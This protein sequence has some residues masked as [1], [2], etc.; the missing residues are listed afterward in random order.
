MKATFGSSTIAY[1]GDYFE[2]KGSTSTMVKYYYAGGQRVAM[3]VG[4][5]TVYYLLTDHLGSTAITANSSGSRVAELR[6]KAWGETRYTY[7]TTPTAYK[8]TERRLDGSTDCT[9]IGPVPAS[10]LPGPLHQLRFP[11]ATGRQSPT[12]IPGD[13]KSRLPLRSRPPPT[14]GSLRRQAL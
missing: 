9:T 6:Y 12:P 2:W 3:R 4:T 10:P 5:S 11:T 14:P 7:G 13:W 1:V 8:F